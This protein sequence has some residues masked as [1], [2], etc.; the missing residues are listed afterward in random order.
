MLEG[1]RS[2]PARRHLFHQQGAVELRACLTM[3]RLLSPA[4]S[5][6]CDG[7]RRIGGIE[8]GNE[9]RP[10]ARRTDEIEAEGRGVDVHRN[11]AAAADRIGN[12][13]GVCVSD[14][15]REGAERIVASA[16][17][18]RRDLADKSRFQMMPL[19]IAVAIA[20]ARLLADSFWIAW[21][22]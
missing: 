14:A 2:T 21:V 16:E 18:R 15:E 8:A 13:D 11:P 22:M 5:L 12:G 20:I 6:V 19:L 1:L 9:Q 7:D 17:R 3:E 10:L 4:I